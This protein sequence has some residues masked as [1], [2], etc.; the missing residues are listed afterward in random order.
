MEKR[1]VVYLVKEEK[2]KYLQ[3][4]IVT[5]E[6]LGNTGRELPTVVV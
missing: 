5:R 2:L 3:I 1:E 4:K 6:M